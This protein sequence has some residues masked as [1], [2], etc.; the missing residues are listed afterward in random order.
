MCG[1]CGVVGLESQ[2]PSGPFRRR[3]AASL[4]RLRH[5]GP[6]EVH[7]ADAGTGAIGATRLAIRGLSIAHRNQTLPAPT[8]SFGVSE[9]PVSGANL[10]D[11]IKAADL[12]LYRAKRAG[13]DQ[14]CAAEVAETQP[15]EPG[16]PP[17]APIRLG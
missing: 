15:V 13:R 6:D 14:V 8:A 5:R 1:I 17:H 10:E 7:L 4:Q 3:A 12:A 2:E 16:Q 9:Y 11:F